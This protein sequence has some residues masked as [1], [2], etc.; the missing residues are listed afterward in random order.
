M[1]GSE[2]DPNE[3]I[4][5]VVYMDDDIMQQLDEGQIADGDEDATSF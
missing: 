3:E 5:D 4:D 2:A 1:A